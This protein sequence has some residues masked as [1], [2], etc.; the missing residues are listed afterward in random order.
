ME[1]FVNPGNEAF[2]RV[3]KTGKYVDKIG[4]IEFTNHIIYDFRPFVENRQIDEQ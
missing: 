4:M 1:K 2:Q 3:V